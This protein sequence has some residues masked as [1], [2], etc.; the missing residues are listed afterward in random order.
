MPKF[1]NIRYSLNGNIM[2]N[3]EKKEHIIQTKIR[4]HTP[5]KGSIGK[6][7]KRI[8]QGIFELLKLHPCPRYC[9]PFSGMIN[10]NWEYN[11]LVQPEESSDSDKK[12]HYFVTFTHSAAQ[13]CGTWTLDKNESLS[14]N[15]LTFRVDSKQAKLFGPA[16]TLTKTIVYTCERGTCCIQCPCNLC[17]SCDE[18]C[19]R[20]CAKSP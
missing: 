4:D 2:Q 18:P 14:I 3:Y 10:G 6:P 19:N 5:V 16:S 9:G 15:S 13:T 12:F 7:C 20:Y 8:R 1:G 17:T 11:R